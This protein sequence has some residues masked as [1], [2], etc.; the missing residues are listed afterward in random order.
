VFDLVSDIFMI[1]SYLG[2]AETRGVAHASIA[3]VALNLLTQLLGVWFVNR[4]R[5][6]RRIARELLYVR[7]RSERKNRAGGGN[8]K[9]ALVHKQSERK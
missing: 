8:I 3:C 5:S 1:V 9:R 7:E 4:K 6:W 2:S